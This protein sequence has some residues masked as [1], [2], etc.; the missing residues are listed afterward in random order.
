MTCES[1][2]HRDGPPRSTTAAPGPG[3]PSCHAGR[4]R[5]TP[6][7]GP[8]RHGPGPTATASHE[9]RRS[10]APAAPWWTCSSRHLRQ[11][12]VEIQ[13]APLDR[14]HHDLLEPTAHPAQ[15]HGRIDAAIA[16]AFVV[17][18]VN[19]E[20]LPAAPRMLGDHVAVVDD[21]HD[22]GTAADLDPQAAE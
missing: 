15:G 14:L 16:V 8:P 11:L 18:R 5:S 17:A 12:G 19:Q 20:S 3:A 6:R 13:G 10:P 4:R 9:C 21:L 22:R 7:P 1:A 2:A